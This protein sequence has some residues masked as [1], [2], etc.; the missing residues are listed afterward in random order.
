MKDGYLN[1]LVITECSHQATQFKKILYVLSV[2]CVDKGYKYV[3]DGIHKNK[4]LDKMKHFL[5]YPNAINGG[6]N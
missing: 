6:E 2:S 4:E 3:N 1:K 5:D